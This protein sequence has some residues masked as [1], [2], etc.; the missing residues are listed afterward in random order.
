MKKIRTFLAALTA[1]TMCVG[2]VQCRWHRCICH[3]C[4]LWQV[5]NPRTG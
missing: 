2:A 3:R 4:L 5:R 1:V